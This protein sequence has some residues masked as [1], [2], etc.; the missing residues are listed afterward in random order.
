MSL[1]SEELN[2]RIIE[3]LEEKQ[4][5]E[6]DA[7]VLCT[8]FKDEVDEVWL[9]YEELKEKSDKESKENIELR[10]KNSNIMAHCDDLN[11][12][13]GQAKEELKDLK[14]E[15]EYLKDEICSKALAVSL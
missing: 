5:L 10:K 9:N 13:I 8:G 7:N 1:F 6:M 11:K 4:K 12:K 2:S 3:L 15:K 14:K